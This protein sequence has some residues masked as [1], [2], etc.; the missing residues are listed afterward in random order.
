M[1]RLD[2]RVAVVTGGARGIGRAC[3]ERLAQEGAAVAF[4]QRDV[5][6]EDEVGM[7]FDA[8]AA[9]WG[10]VD[11]VVNNAAI[12]LL[13]PVTDTSVEQFRDLFDTNVLS[14]FHTSRFA[15]PQMLARGGGSIVNV[16]SIAS[17]VGLLDDAAYCSTKGAVHSLTR[18]MSLD[19]ATRGIRVNCVAPGFIETDQMRT[20]IASHGGDAERVRR[21]IDAS[22]PM[23]R[24]G[25]PHEVASVVA[26]LASDDASFMT[27]STVVVD[28]GLLAR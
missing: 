20:Y 19:Y 25:Q 26:F 24:V 17:E 8:V 5:R 23:N 6:L 18:Q 10:G 4:T 11:V 14:I 2:G 3:T 9:R 7:V 1:R 22:H 12:G 28:G 13:K 21:E 27:G 15:I 16:G